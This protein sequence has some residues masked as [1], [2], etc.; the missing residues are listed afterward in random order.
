MWTIKEFPIVVSRALA[1]IGC[2]EQSSG[3]VQAL[4]NTRA[5]RFYASCGLLEKPEIRGRTAYYNWRHLLHVVAIK[6]LQAT[7]NLSLA[8]VQERLPRDADIKEL[9][10]AAGLPKGFR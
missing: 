3:R 9:E 2:E 7:E 5:I 8:E 4:P 1:A 10:E 6:R